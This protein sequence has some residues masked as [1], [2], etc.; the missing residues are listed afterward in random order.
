MSIIVNNIWR[1]LLNSR[2]SRSKKVNYSEQYLEKAVKF[3]FI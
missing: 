3:T 1:K 2:L